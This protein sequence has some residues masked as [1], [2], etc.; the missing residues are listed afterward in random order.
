MQEGLTPEAVLD[1]VREAGFEEAADYPEKLGKDEL[2]LLT[3]MLEN[4]KGLQ[5]ARK[6]KL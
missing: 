6:L 1:L 5:E 3:K 4:Y 2:L